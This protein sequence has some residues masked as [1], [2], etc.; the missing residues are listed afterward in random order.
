MEL[1]KLLA[2]NPLALSLAVMGLAFALGHII[3]SRA[4]RAGLKATIIC[5][6]GFAALFFGFLLAGWSVE[7]PLWK[8]IYG[9]C[10]GICLWIFY[11]E[12]LETLQGEFKITTGVEVNYG[13]IPLLAVLGLAGWLVVFRYRLISEPALLQCLNS[14]YLTWL[15][16]VVLLT[17]YY[18]PAFGGRTV[19]RGEKTP[20]IKVWTRARL[21]AAWT[22]G[23]VYAL[24][25]IPITIYTALTS[26]STAIRVSCGYYLV[27]LGW[28]VLMELRKKLF[29]P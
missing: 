15:L 24:A 20:A 13:N 12:T 3:P 11:G 10:A 29:A 22:V 7:S 16:H 8:N 18:A 17:V 4:Y 25:L 6:A 28:S 9:L 2:E 5:G 19:A 21:A 23:L 26:E 1:I 27:I 14:F